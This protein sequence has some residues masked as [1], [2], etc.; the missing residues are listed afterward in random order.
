M[1]ANVKGTNAA[2]DL[3][4]VAVKLSDIKDSTMDAIAVA[5][6]GDST[7]IQVGERPS[8][9]GTPWVMGSL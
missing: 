9:S 7:Q 5:T 6:L 2:K 8:L 4:V 3:A 1:E